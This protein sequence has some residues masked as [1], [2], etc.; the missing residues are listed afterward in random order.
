[1][2]AVISLVLGLGLWHFWT[3]K[4]TEPRS[5]RWELAVGLFKGALAIVG[6]L[7]G[8]G[9]ALWGA[10]WVIHFLWRIT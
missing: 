10:V 7:V 2:R 4:R 3:R 6:T 5:E 1:M 8:I 9:L